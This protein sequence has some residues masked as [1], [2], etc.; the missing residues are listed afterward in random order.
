[1]ANG[2]GSSGGRGGRGVGGR[3]LVDANYLV[4]LLL[5]LSAFMYRY[6]Y[7]YIFASDKLVCL[8]A[9]PPVARSRV[10]CRKLN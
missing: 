4:S 5:L 6:K 7:I 10:H 2:D 8:L 9:W 1:M 3:W